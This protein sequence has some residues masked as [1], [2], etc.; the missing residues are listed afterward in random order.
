MEGRN[1]PKRLTAAA[2][3]YASGDGSPPAEVSELYYIERFGVE[4]AMGRK[5]LRVG[6]MRR[7]VVVDNILTAY[8]SRKA[9]EDWAK[10]AS[11]NPANARLLN[12]VE[13]DINAD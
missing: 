3:H 4:A 9:A 6:E 2:Y 12:D 1:R 7:M 13:K 10:W 5:H 11:D 8:K